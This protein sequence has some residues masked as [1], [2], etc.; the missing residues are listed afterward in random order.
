MYQRNWLRTASLHVNN[1]CNVNCILCPER[2]P[3]KKSLEATKKHICELNDKNI[4]KLDF[5]KFNPVE[6]NLP[7]NP[8]EIICH[9]RA[10][11]K[12][13]FLRHLFFT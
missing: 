5:L 4:E 7:N 12:E 8:D 2:F 9:C 3:V 1:T 6:W 13:R 10:R 11:R